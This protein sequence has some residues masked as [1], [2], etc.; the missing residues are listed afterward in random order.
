MLL[1]LQLLT[2]P[3]ISAVADQQRCCCCCCSHEL[4][5]LLVSCARQAV[6]SVLLPF[7]YCSGPAVAAYSCYCLLHCTD[8][9]LGPAAALDVHVSGSLNAATPAH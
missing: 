1:L 6:C 8:C 7:A 5:L 4:L 3:A 2:A 9:S